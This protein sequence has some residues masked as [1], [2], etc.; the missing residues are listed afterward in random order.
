MIRSESASP[1]R[2]FGL[3]RWRIAGAGAASLGYGADGRRI[4]KKVTGVTKARGAPEV[5]C[6]S[7]RAR[8]RGAAFLMTG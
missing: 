7:Y 2:G 3:P 5:A 8:R 1:W 6:P 4:R